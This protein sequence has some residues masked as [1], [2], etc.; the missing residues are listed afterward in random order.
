MSADG[1]HN[2][3][4]LQLLKAEEASTADPLIREERAAVDRLLEAGDQPRIYGFTTLLGHL[5]DQ[6]AGSDSQERLLQ[7]HLVGNTFA[8]PPSWV[9]LTLAC[10]L[11]QLSAGGSGIH[12]D[13]YSALRDILQVEEGPTA[14]VLLNGAW[15][16]SYSSG[17]VVPGAW[18]VENL[19]QHHGLELRQPGDLIT[20]ING[21]F[22]STAIGIA[23]HN[24]FLRVAR[25]ARTLLY[26]VQSFARER[27]VAR[28]V[29]LSVT[30]R[31]LSPIEANIE[32]AASQLHECLSNRLLNISCNPRFFISDGHTEYASQSSFLDFTLTSALSAATQCTSQMA[33]YLKG[34][35]RL[36]ESLTAADDNSPV[37][38]T[39]VVQSM[40]TR[41]A[42]LSS[43]SPVGFTISESN[44]VEDV[45]DL[46]LESSIQ[47]IRI[48]NVLEEIV[49]IAREEAEATGI[50]FTPVVEPDCCFDLVQ[51]WKLVDIEQALSANL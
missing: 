37:Q 50:P 39:K 5:D 35:V 36:R 41:M 43:G 40:I 22:I 42:N 46:S 51:R 31:D 19:R 44:G 13:T 47:L 23:A 30:M 33:A 28:S 38:P 48:L 11:S 12:P 1:L 7:A 20:L 8:M 18:L 26:S 16:S 27:E 49:L 2:C 4:L 6:D 15:T 14:G 25:A 9:R 21:N 45:C 24:K 10:K 32:R 3:E 34:S 29:Q 17:D